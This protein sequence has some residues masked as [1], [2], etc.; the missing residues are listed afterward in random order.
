MHSVVSSLGQRIILPHSKGDDARDNEFLN[1]CLTRRCTG[2][3]G[4]GTRLPVT[5]ALGNRKSLL[6]S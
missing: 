3:A 4:K 2:S 5:F 1:G 6:I